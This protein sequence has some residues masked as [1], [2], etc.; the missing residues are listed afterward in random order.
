ME[1]PPELLGQPG[2][3]CGAGLDPEEDRCVSSD[4]SDSDTDA[5]LPSV[6]A[7]SALDTLRTAIDNSA[8]FR[9]P[10]DVVLSSTHARDE[11]ACGSPKGELDPSWN[12]PQQE[13]SSK[14]IGVHT[15]L[16]S[17]ASSLSSDSPGSLD[18]RNSSHSEGAYPQGGKKRLV[19]PVPASPSPASDGQATKPAQGKRA[20]FRAAY[21]RNQSH[22]SCDTA[23]A[24]VVPRVHAPA[25]DMVLSAAMA[26][27]AGSFSMLYNQPDPRFAQVAQGGHT[28]HASQAIA[29]PDADFGA[30][31]SS[32]LA[33]ERTNGRTLTQSNSKR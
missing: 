27:T 9:G 15:S 31:R 4:T 3:A 21:L 12:T 2:G 13:P 17:M 25:S 22:S 28:P 1:A 23:N 18:N 30:L 19:S 26:S 10:S 32:R 11:R 14:A 24:E 16:S 6:G 8:G 29:T 33:N 5:E 7:L 20:S